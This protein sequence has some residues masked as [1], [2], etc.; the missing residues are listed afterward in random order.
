MLTR[1]GDFD[2]SF[3]LFD[4]LRKRLDRVW[5]DFDDG[6]PSVIDEGAN[7]V[8]KAD[9]PGVQDKDLQL[10]LNA[11]SLTIA[12]ERKVEAPQGYSVHRQER[13]GTSFTRTLVLPTKVDAERTTA[14]I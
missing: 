7:L 12:G 10:T 6:S 14:V 3:T 1:F 11:E 9:I 13:A 2:R 4:E 5:V 8:L